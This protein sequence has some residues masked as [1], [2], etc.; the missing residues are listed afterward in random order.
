M[1]N[2]L[3]MR[4]PSPGQLF[5]FA[6][7]RPLTRQLLSSTIQSLLRS[8]GY[9][10]NYSGHSFWIGAATTAASRGLPNHLFKT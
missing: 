5:Y 1:G 9:S 4:G 8:A 10:G 7:G 2:F 6:D 3:A